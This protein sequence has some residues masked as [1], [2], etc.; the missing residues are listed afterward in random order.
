MSVTRI[1]E[2]LGYADIYFFSKQF[3][4]WMGEAPLRYRERMQA[5]D[6]WHG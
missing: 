1:A 4:Q 2:T 5:E 6:R 3:K